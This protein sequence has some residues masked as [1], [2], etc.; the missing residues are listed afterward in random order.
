MSAPRA[1]QGASVGWWG[2]VGGWVA[3]RSGGGSYILGNVNFDG[4]PQ[5][6]SFLLAGAAG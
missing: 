2:G 6:V 3:L 1:C 5:N 4:W